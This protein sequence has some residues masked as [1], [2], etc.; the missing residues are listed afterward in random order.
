MKHKYKI[1]WKV[2]ITASNHGLINV[3]EE[4]VIDCY[5]KDGYG[6]AF[7][8]WWPAIVGHQIGVTEKRVI[9]FAEG[10]FK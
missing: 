1:G 10:T 9:F 5:H 8:K 4:G 7:T 3:G 6:I 2:T